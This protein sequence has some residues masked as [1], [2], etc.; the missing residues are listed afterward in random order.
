MSMRM[1][2]EY[3]TCKCHSIPPG[4]GNMEHMIPC[5]MECPYCHMN[6]VGELFDYH[7]RVSHPNIFTGRARTEESHA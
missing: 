6:V 2:E 4:E 5:C 7:V 3:C 1:E